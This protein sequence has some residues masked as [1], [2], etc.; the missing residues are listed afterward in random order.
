[1]LAEKHANPKIKTFTDAFY[2]ISTCASVGFADI[3]AV[4]QSGKAIASLVM[5]VGP[6]LTA[7]A[8]TRPEEKPVR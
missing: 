7:K 2:Y 6:S 5:T 8:L 1:Y 4:T 3:F